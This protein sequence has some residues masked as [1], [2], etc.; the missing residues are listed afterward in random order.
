MEE[1]FRNKA[2]F[3]AIIAACSAQVLKF[4]LSIWTERRCDWSRLCET[5]GMPSAHTAGVVALAISVG[6]LQG[7][8][9]VA[10]AITAVFAY[11]VIYDA[12]NVRRAAG[13]HAHLLNQLVVELEELFS[14]DFQPEQLKTLLGHSYPQVFFGGVVGAVISLCLLH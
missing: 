1:L 5:G 12:T 13:Q 7:W 11:I 2:L 8:A 14:G 9:S 10:F 4:L 3:A 6:R